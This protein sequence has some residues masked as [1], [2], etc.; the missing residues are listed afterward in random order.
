MPTTSSDSAAMPDGG[1]PPARSADARPVR[2]APRNPM[3][4]A[5]YRLDRL[6]LRRIAYS[7]ATIWFAGLFYRRTL[8][9]R[10]GRGLAH[11]PREVWLGD[12]RCGS[13]ILK[14]EYAF[15][16]HAES[17][18]R[19]LWRNKGAPEAWQAAL[20]GFDWLRDLRAVG[21]KSARDHAR[22]MIVDWLEREDRWHPLSWR[23]DVISERLTNWL[24]AAE[25]VYPVEEPLDAKPFL[26]SL[27]R[28]SR[29]L[30]RVVGLLDPGTERL[31]AL[32]ALVLTGVCIPAQAR[33]LPRWLDMLSAESVA[34]I[35]LDGVHVTRSPTMQLLI[36]R[37]LVEL[38]GVLRDAGIDTPQPIESAISRMAA[39]LRQ[40]RHGDGRLCL[41]NDSDEEEN[42][43][44]D[45]VLSRADPPGHTAVAP[46]AADAGFQ[47][48]SAGGTIVL[49]DAGPPPPPGFDRHAHAGTLSF[50]MSAGRQ[51]MI[52]NCG[53]YSGLREDW[54]FAQ[55]AT[56][57]HSTLTIDDYN[58][59]DVLSTEMIGYRP[60]IAGVDRHEADG[61]LWLDARIE[62]YGG[63][64]GLSHQRR[65]Y[66]TANGA[67]LRGED[68]LSGKRPHRF[69]ARF[70]LHP[71]VTASLAQNEESVLLRLRDGDGWRFRAEGGVV[72][73]Q[74]SVYLGFRGRPRRTLQIVITGAKG[75]GTATL[76]WAFVRLGG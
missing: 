20:H 13:A 46:A 41:F 28:Q 65:L 22:A 17:D 47:R 29:H 26:G 70:H 68:T 12:A 43:L 18:P 58:S 72:S 71:S 56:A 62:N 73:L 8:G 31:R 60:R 57:A 49:M 55:R 30:G 35:G 75:S 66:L 37:R 59:A 25:Y 50:E 34:Q 39:A 3:R 38:H 10:Y 40:L 1:T 76:K 14:K 52:V 21:G 61:N 27:I 19:N 54:R 15:A 69:V 6:T 74:E 7:V 24:M 36:L 63:I 33:S 45:L 4:L 53:A 23:P 67:N 5:L 48:L 9:G 51:R 42:W 32:C 11:A 16:G 64:S 2:K 44:I